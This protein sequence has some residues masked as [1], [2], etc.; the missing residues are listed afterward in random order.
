MY[1]SGMHC[2]N[3]GSACCEGQIHSALQCGNG[4]LFEQIF[5]PL[6]ANTRKISQIS[7]RS[8]NSSDFAGYWI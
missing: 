8:V 3:E 6:V 5:F 4:T 7:L 1:D 2:F